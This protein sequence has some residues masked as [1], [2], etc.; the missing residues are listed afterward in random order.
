MATQLLVNV[1]SVGPIAPLG[2]AVIPH[3]LKSAGQGVV[4]TQVICDRASPLSITNA[5]ATNIYIINLSAS[6]TASANFRAEYDHSIHAVGATPLNWRGYTPTYAPAGVA[7]Y[8]QFSDTTDQPVSAGGIAIAKYNTTDAAN[9]VSVVNDPITLRPTRLT[10]GSTGVYAFTVSPQVQ[11]TGGGTV[12]II[13]WPR[14]D[15]V[16]VPNSASSF[17]M[18]NNNNRTIPFFEFISPMTAGQYMEWVFYASGNNTSLEH[19]NA[20]VGPPAIP[21]IPSIIAGVKLIGS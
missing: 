13:F 20:V 7:V 11:H 19:F 12:T 9:G 18:G 3:G 10:V 15:G 17:E 21:A 5:D 4:P 16:D 2:A 1:L 6:E 14:I 8:G